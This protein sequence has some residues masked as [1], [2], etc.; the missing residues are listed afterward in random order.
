MVSK[1]GDVGAGEYGS[2]AAAANARER[3]VAHPGPS[4]EAL[5]NS[6]GAVISDDDET[7][8]D[9]EEDRNMN[10]AIAASFGTAATT[11]TTARGTTADS[12]AKHAREERGGRDGDRAPV[13]NGRPS[14]SNGRS[15]SSNGRSPSSDDRPSPP[16]PPSHLP[17]GDFFWVDSHWLRQWTV[18]E[19]LP[20]VTTGDGGQT[21]GAFTSPNEPC[22]S[23]KGTSSANPLVL[24]EVNGATRR[25]SR[26]QEASSNAPEQGVVE[27]FGSD[28]GRDV[29]AKVVN[30]GDRRGTGAT[31][32]GACAV[33]GMVEI[34]GHTGAGARVRP[35]RA[36]DST[37][38]VSRG[39]RH[40]RMGTIETSDSVND[41]VRE[42]VKG[43]DDKVS[44]PIPMREDNSEGNLEISPKVNSDT[45]AE[46]SSERF[47]E[48]ELEESTDEM[49]AAKANAGASPPWNQN[50]AEHR[51]D[52]GTTLGDRPGSLCGA[53]VSCQEG[54]F[55]EPM[56]HVHLLCEHG[57]LHPASVS[58]LK[59]VTRKV[60]EGFLTED[61]MPWPDYHLAASNYRCERCVKN[62]IGQK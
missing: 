27:V 13:E 4:D 36:G 21:G 2:A 1:G 7:E 58:R 12:T 17:P 9:S 32:D 37:G 11:T 25:Q 30:S 16:S 56:R 26:D 8:R 34:E 44:S 31:G 59:V 33:G 14:S 23:G 24:E 19:H 3:P 20:N 60:Y 29:D 15:S 61:G 47:G 50:P 22:F 5:S 18:G 53:S 46:R 48:I 39:A 55:R 49:S 38:G 62:H 6:N 41:A 45:N 42:A 40:D 10:E 28:C 43:V 57:G 51:D 54:V 35:K 52:Q